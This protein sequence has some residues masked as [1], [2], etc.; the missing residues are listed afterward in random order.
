MSVPK[1]YVL[2]AHVKGPQS[3]KNSVST[4]QIICI[5]FTYNI[6]NFIYMYY[7]HDLSKFIIPNISYISKRQEKNSL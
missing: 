7:I 5:F 1:L 4:S 3:L 6:K 2:Y